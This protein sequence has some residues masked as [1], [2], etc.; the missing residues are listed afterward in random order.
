MSSAYPRACLR[1]RGGDPKKAQDET[2]S[3]WYKWIDQNG[4]KAMHECKLLGSV[5]YNLSTSSMCAL[6]MPCTNRPFKC[7][8]PGCNMTYSMKTHYADNHQGAKMSE[9]VKNQVLLKPHD[10]L[11]VNRLVVAYTK[12]IKTVCP[13]LMK[14]MKNKE[15]TCTCALECD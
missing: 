4:K 9:D 14:A 12:G 6:S 3:G 7:K 5:S 15:A 11:Y 2:V 10:C 1:V 8:M 13:T